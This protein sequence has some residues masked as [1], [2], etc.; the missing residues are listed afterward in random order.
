ML[1]P[2][3]HWSLL[4]CEKTTNLNALHKIT[5]LKP[6]ILQT[7]PEDFVQCHMEGHAD[8]LISDQTYLLKVHTPYAYNFGF[9]EPGSGPGICILT[10]APGDCMQERHTGIIKGKSQA[11]FHFI[12]KNSFQH[13]LYGSSSGKEAPL[14]FVCLKSLS[15]FFISGRQNLPDILFWQF[16]FL[17]AV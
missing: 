16:F 14:A 3:S 10:S 6:L 12:W 1:L 9:S 8:F 7:R 17:S 4:Y 2:P 13:F 11:S 15:L 5:E